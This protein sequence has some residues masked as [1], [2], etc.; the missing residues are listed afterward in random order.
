MFLMQAR[1]KSTV[2]EENVRYTT[3][4]VRWGNQF[5]IYK[6]QVKVKYKE[7]S[8]KEEPFTSDKLQVKPM[9]LSHGLFL[10]KPSP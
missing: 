6:L 4:D 1:I 5:T 9:P 3:Y 7:R 8:T 2:V 10:H